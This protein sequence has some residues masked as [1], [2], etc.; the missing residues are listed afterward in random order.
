MHFSY[1]NLIV[2]LLAIGT[3][4][5]D[6]VLYLKNKS[7]RTIHVQPFVGDQTFEAKPIRANDDAPYTA[8]ELG[9]NMKIDG[10]RVKYCMSEDTQC[11][12]DPALLSASGKAYEFKF[13]KKARDAAKKYYLKL[14]IE[15]DE[16]SL[17]P[18]KGIL[19]RTENRKWSLSGNIKGGDEN[20][21][22]PTPYYAA[23][24]GIV[25]PPSSAP[26]SYA[27]AS[28]FAK[29]SSS[30]KA[31]A[32]VTS[33]M[34]AG[35]QK[36]KFSTPPSDMPPALPEMNS[37]FSIKNNSSYFLKL[38]LIKQRGGI[39]TSSLFPDSTN[40]LPKIEGPLTGFRIIYSPTSMDSDV[41]QARKNGKIIEFIFNAPN[42]RKYFL[43]INMDKS[44]GFLLMTQ[45][46][47]KISTEMYG[48]LGDNIK[49]DEISKKRK[50]PER[51]TIPAPTD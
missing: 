44:G 8:E 24:E 5:A 46:D 21:K 40:T 20:I 7:D 18:Q 16:A 47:E 26:S 14:T 31:T 3:I 13:T 1:T 15:G 45:K 19:G 50:A 33:D 41:E 29:A 43:E 25:V 30:A 10:V 23:Q 42:K 34:S 11:N 32:D 12:I 49:Q 35:M 27:G 22:G 4:H 39:T 6:P 37:V 36:P 51:P 48:G 2:A 38:E 9:N 17:E 28:N